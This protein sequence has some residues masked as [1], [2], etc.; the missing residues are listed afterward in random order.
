[1]LQSNEKIIKHK[2]GLLNLAEE[3]GNVSKACQ[4][5]GLSRDTFYLEIIEIASLAFEY[6]EEGNPS[7]AI[8]LGTEIRKT[9]REIFKN[10]IFTRLHSHPLGPKYPLGCALN[11][12][13]PDNPQIRG[14]RTIVPPP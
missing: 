14:N 8:A 7:P 6:L 1:M 9:A 2:V 4:I 5:M 11:R 3:L 10:R 13:F 12:H